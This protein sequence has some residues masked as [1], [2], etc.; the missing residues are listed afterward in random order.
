VS[1]S[2]H[3]RL[4][5][6]REAFRLVGECRDVG[7]DPEAWR[8][9]AFRELVRL[10]GGRAAAGGEIRWRRP[11]PSIIVVQ[12]LDEGLPPA[13]RAVFLDYMQVHGPMH[14]P[15]TSS[16]KRLRGRLVTR[17]RRQ[18]VADSE[19]Y[20]ADFFH[21]YH[22]GAGLDHCINSLCEPAADGTIDVIG[23]HR[24]V[25]DRDFSPRERRLLHL[26][27]DELGRLIGP[28][29]EW[30]GASAVARLSPR[31]RQ[32]LDALREGDSEKQVAARLGISQPTAHEYVH[33]LYRHFGVSSRAELL[34]RFIRRPPG[35]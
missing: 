29:L 20:G 27:H 2:R 16:L 7:D 5:E 22:R 8:R 1:K 4:R 11:A 32:T 12:S 34:A 13:D 33:R 21:R 19:W 6:L 18:L 14:D 35:L 28:V 25:G 9:H 24:A 26:V 23:V 15:I 3:L 17:T 31:L 30:A 10:I